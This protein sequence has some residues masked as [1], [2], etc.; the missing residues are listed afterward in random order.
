MVLLLM[1]MKYIL[2]PKSVST[3]PDECKGVGLE[4]STKPKRKTTNK[5]LVED[6]VSANSN[7]R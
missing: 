3:I 6:I 2:N 5:K 4:I 7:I 1:I